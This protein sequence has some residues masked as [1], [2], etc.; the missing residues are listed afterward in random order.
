MNLFFFL[1][2]IGTGTILSSTFPL[3]AGNSKKIAVVCFQKDEIEL[4]SYWIQYHAALFG[5]QNIIVLDNFSKSSETLS[6]LKKWSDLGVRVYYNQGPYHAKGIL[7]AN[8]F[9]KLKYTH[10]LEFHWMP[11]NFSSPIE[12][13]FPILIGH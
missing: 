11:M 1:L 13:E 8:A 6:V 12:T 10:K 9:K 5:T 2:L 4:L 3:F 7:T